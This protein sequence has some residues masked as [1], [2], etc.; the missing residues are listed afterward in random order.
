[1]IAVERDGE[2]FDRLGELLDTVQ[3]NNTLC[4]SG[5]A[6]PN[7]SLLVRSIL[8]TEMTGLITGYGPDRRELSLWNLRLSCVY[9]GAIRRDRW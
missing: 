7:T 2:R 6:E 8:D 9:W 3:P 5:S 1:M 4:R